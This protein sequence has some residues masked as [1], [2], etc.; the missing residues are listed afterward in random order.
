MLK[1]AAH[2]AANSSVPDDIASTRCHS[3]NVTLRADRDEQRRFQCVIAV[4]ELGLQRKMIITSRT[5][6]EVRTIA[7]E[8]FRLSEMS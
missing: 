5:D 1:R 7:H 3:L 4:K 6:M 8:C 2:P